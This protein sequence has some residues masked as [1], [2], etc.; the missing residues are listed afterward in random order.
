MPKAKSKSSNSP[1]LTAGPLRTGLV[2]L[3][4]LSVLANL[5]ALLGY[6]LIVHNHHYD[7]GLYNFTQR[8]VCG[9]YSQLTDKEQQLYA[10]FCNK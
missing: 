9:D 1:I 2:I 10:N 4:S 8:K 7:T 5:G 6:V 3:I